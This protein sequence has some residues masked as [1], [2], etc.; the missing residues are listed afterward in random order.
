MVDD[1]GA[2]FVIGVFYAGDI[3]VAYLAAAAAI[4]AGAVMLRR[5]VKYGA[6]VYL[7]LAAALWL[8]LYGAGVQASIAGA[9]IGLCAPFAR[10]GLG[11]L[12]VGEQLEV[13]LYPLATYLV[14]PLFALANAGVVLT[15]LDLSDANAWRVGIGI[16]AGLLVGKLVG[17]TAASWLVVRAGLAGLPTGA[18]WRQL[19][20]VAGVAGIGF[21]VALFVADLA[22]VG[23]PN[24]EAVAKVSILLTSVV[25][26]VIGSA[27]LWRPRH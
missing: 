25:A 10:S 16:F 2:I 11:N 1:I 19:M 24:L 17:I 14:I 27:L 22:F 6:A 26:A 15:G 13:A 18:T 5:T 9:I 20:G 4:V 8:A 23:Q 12:S 7:G 21:T 3:N